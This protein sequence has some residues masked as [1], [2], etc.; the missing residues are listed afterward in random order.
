ML[1]GASVFV[2]NSDGPESVWSASLLQ[3]PCRFRGL[4]FIKCLATLLVES[5]FIPP[6]LQWL[7][8]H[9]LAVDCGR[10]ERKHFSARGTTG[11]TVQVFYFRLTWVNLQRAATAEEKQSNKNNFVTV[12]AN[13][14]PMVQSKFGVTRLHNAHMT[15]KTVINNNWVIVSSGSL[16]E[17]LRRINIILCQTKVLFALI[18]TALLNQVPVPR[19]P[20]KAL[21]TNLVANLAWLGIQ[22]EIPLICPANR[23]KKMSLAIRIPSLIR[24]LLVETRQK[25]AANCC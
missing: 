10:A 17:C 11:D 19:M 2:P 8:Q 24:F 9:S 22:W 21:T 12:K 15:R 25:C 16:N 3:L 13:V 7:G 4:M 6:P 1:V 14:S 5:F 23:Q 18:T 20:I